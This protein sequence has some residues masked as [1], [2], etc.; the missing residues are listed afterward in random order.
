MSSLQQALSQTTFERQAPSNGGL[1]PQIP[2]S[3]EEEQRKREREAMEQI[4]QQQEE[5]EKERLIREQQQ[6]AEKE[7]QRKYLQDR[8]S[9]TQS[10]V[11]PGFMNCSTDSLLSLP[12]GSSTSSSLRA[13]TLSASSVPTHPQSAPSMVSPPQPT[14]SVTIPPQPHPVA[15]IPGDESESESEEEDRELNN[16]ID[17][18]QSSIDQRETEQSEEAKEMKRRLQ[19]FKELQQ[20]KSQC[21]R[22]VGKEAEE[23]VKQIQVLDAEIAQLRDEI[24]RY[25]EIFQRANGLCGV[26]MLIDRT[27]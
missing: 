3:W 11:L 18:L 24:T 8:R 17:S 22:E 21:L 7:Q 26:W 6:R 4:R 20:N 2:N 10:T 5:V 12:G 27:K 9:L 16:V 23:S 1:F 15:P 13:A 19:R 14:P 25:L